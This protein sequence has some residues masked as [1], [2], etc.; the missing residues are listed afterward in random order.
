[1]ELAGRFINFVYRV[2]NILTSIKF[3]IYHIMNAY[4]DLC[5]LHITRYISFKVHAITIIYICNFLMDCLKVCKTELTYYLMQRESAA[6]LT[7]SLLIHNIKL[8]YERVIYL[9]H[10]LCILLSYK[11][12]R[13]KKFKIL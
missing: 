10:L 5:T 9:V 3:F 13:T 2:S 6:C 11:R 12:Y 1:M 8:T 7:A 4:F